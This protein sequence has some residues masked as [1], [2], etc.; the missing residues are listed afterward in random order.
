VTEEK[1]SGFVIDG[2]TYLIPTLDTFNMDEGQVLYDYSGSVVEDFAPA[3]P[4]SSKDE[5]DE[6]ERQILK[7]AKSP[8]FKKA[9]LHVAFARGNPQESQS[10]VREIVGQ[11]N[12]L[13][14]TLAL[15]GGDDESP[16]EVTPSPIELVKPSASETPSNGSASGGLSPS[17]SDPPDEIHVPTGITRSDTSSPLS[18]LST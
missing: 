12:I 2:K 13:E 18:A 10:K 7:L 15:Y 11:V 1:E 4:R 16:P 8:G 14:A 17:D 5:Q 3:D 6:H 9:L